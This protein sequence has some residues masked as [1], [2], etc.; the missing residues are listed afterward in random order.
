M[1]DTPRERLRQRARFGRWADFP[2]NPERFYERFR[3]TV[4]REGHVSKGKSFSVVDRMQARLRDLDGPRR[5]V[6]D[7]LGLYRAVHTAGLALADNT[8]D[9]YGALG[10][11]R[12]EAW[13]TYLSIDWRSTGIDPTVYWRDLCELRIW[14]LYAVDH[15]NSTAWFRIRNAEEVDLIE[16]IL[17]DLETEHRSVVLDW[18]A[19][20][21]C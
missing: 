4:E 8:N 9:S 13:L 7:R 15:G 19:D 16:A 21:A 5:T 17:V 14:E 18:E 6:T 1:L 11:T 3:S 10:E 12:T 2:S 20:E